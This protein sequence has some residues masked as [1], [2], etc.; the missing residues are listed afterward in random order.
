MI[1]ARTTRTTAGPPGGQPPQGLPGGPPGGP[2]QAAQ[3]PHGTNGAMKGQPPTIFNGEQSK[4]NQF[5]TEFQL[6]W[7]TNRRAEAMN[8]PFQRAV[9]CLS[10]IRGP[11]VDNWVEEKIDQLQYAVLGNPANG[12]PPTHHSTDE[13]LWNNFGADFRAA[14]QGT[15]AEEN[16]YA[17]F[18]NLHMIEDRIN[19]CI[20]HLEVLLTRA[21]WSKR[22]KKGQYRKARDPDAMD[23]DTTDIEVSAA[24]TSKGRPKMRCFF[25]DNEGHMK[26]DCHKFK[27]LQKK[28]GSPLPQKAKARV[29]TVEEAKEEK[30]IPPAYNPDSLMVHINNMKIEDCDSFLDQ[31]LVKDTEGF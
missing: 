7:M 2:P 15:A 14:Y 3:A 12:N 19:E 4:T 1:T 9:L 22:N 27:A 26:K 10:F 25:C 16:A 28:G 17:W 30:E 5:V 6:W 29:A 8:N 21:E 24:E 23:V 13:A 31:L 11:K 18:K 20:A